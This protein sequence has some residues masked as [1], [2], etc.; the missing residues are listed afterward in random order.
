MKQLNEKV[1]IVTGAGQGIGKGIAL[2]LAKRGVKVI[3]TGRRPEPIEQTIAEI[4]K[5][6]GEG[7]AMTCDS[8][9]RARVEEVVKAA[10]EKYGTVDVVVNNAQAI[11]PSA[12]VEE[13]TYDNMLK[14]WQSGV[15]GSLNYMQAAFPY[16][17]EQHEG[18]I[19]GIC[20]A[21]SL[22]G[23]KVLDRLGNGRIENVLDAA[24]WIISHQKDLNIRVVNI[25][26]GATT[27]G[28]KENLIALEKA[29]EKLWDNNI[30]VVA[31]A[32]NDGPG[33]QTVAIPGTCKKI[34]TVGSPDGKDFY[35]GRGPTSEC[36]VKPELIVNGSYIR[37]CNNSVN[38]YSIKSG[39]SM[40]APVVSGAIAN[41][42]TKKDMSPKDIKKRLHSCCIKK[43]LPDNLQGW[44]LLN[45]SEFLNI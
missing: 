24:G 25:S 44:G 8:A 28:E 23:I 16:M 19:K 9:D 33:R 31:A 17:K 34:I 41:V 39:T 42:L 12:P 13:T 26:F 7:F 38:G 1:A 4:K 45:I 22:A 10:A 30:I 29:I 11:V 14:A 27:F 36:I 15:I 2:C 37:S 21:A 20:P 5:L 43:A 3:A 6:G 18:R 35:S 32:G 40:S